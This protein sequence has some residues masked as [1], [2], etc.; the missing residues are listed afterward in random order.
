MDA[1]TSVGARNGTVGRGRGVECHEPAAPRSHSDDDLIR[2]K[3]PRI[4]R[5]CGLPPTDVGLIES[6]LRVHLWLVR[7]SI[8]PF[9][10]P[11]ARAAFIDTV[12]NNRGITLVRYYRAQKRDRE[13]E[14][15]LSDCVEAH[16]TYAP[17]SADQRDLRLDM[18][19]FIAGLPPHLRELVEAIRDGRVVELTKRPDWSRRKYHERLAMLK[20][21]C[22]DYGLD[23]YR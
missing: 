15:S 20:R 16:A 14:Q 9:A 1:N 10:D 5:M 17:E 21:A 11:T 13:R 6:D 22:V 3:A 12:L 7:D 4:A 18:Q 2:L 19:A 23:V 8:G